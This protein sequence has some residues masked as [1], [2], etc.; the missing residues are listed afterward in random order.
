MKYLLLIYADESQWARMSEA[1]QGKIFGEHM[2]LVQSLSSA[3]KLLGGEPIEPSSTASTLRLRDGK[4]IVTDGPFAEAR[5]QL[6]GFYLI[7]ASGLDEAL[8][9]AARIPEARVG[10]IEVR[11]VMAIPEG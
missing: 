9:V 1:E 3:G 2:A 11:P 7:E 5:E 8:G 10:V 6:G 4:T